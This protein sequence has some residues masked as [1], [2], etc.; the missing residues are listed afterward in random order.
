MA[1]LEPGALFPHVSLEDASG[2]P[3][4]N[5]K[6]ETLYGFF[7]TTCPTC[8]L[9]WPYLDR[10]RGIARGGP[11]R[12]LAVSQDSPDETAAFNDRLGVGVET[13][14]DRKPWRASED[15]GLENVPTFFLVG[16]DGRI[17]DTFV[18]FQRQKMEQ[19]GARAAKSAGREAWE[20]AVFAPEDDVPAMR[21]G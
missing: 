10:I 6:G 8:E 12:V 5:P 16:G 2:A 20:A 11:L 13:L 14:Y 18:G 21:P 17:R 9:A 4:P 3:A 15:L 19:L 7:K 1:A